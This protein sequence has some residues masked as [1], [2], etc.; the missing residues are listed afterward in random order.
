MAVVQHPDALLGLDIGRIN[1]RVN[2]FGISD[3]KF[4]LLGSRSLATSLGQGFHI[5]T[6]VGQAM[7]SLQQDTGHIFLDDSGGLLK[8][9]DRIGRG[10]DHVALVTSAGQRITAALLGLT[11]Q[12]SLLAGTALVDSLPLNQIET[13]GLVHLVDEINAIEMLVRSR[14]EIIIITGGEDGG[15]EVSIQSWIE[16]VRTSCRLMPPPVK[17]VVLYA[18]N[19]QLESIARRRLEPVARLQIAPNLQPGNG[20]IDL[21]PAQVLLE[22]EILTAWQRAL[23]GL[24]EI[25]GLSQDLSGLTVRS[26]DRMIRYLSRN[27]RHHPGSTSQAGVLAVDLGAAHTTVTAGLGGSCATVVQDKFFDLDHPARAEVCQAIKNWSCEPVSLEEADQFLCNHAIIPA[28]VPETRKELALAQAYAHYR[29]QD[30]LGRLAEN[31]PW[32]EFH[33]NSGLEGNYEPVIVSGGILTAA[34]NP[35]GVMLTLL[36]GLQ[37]RGITTIVLDR[38]HLLPLL[39]IIGQAEPVLPAHLLSSPAFENLGT[40][41][42]VVGDFPTGKAVLTVRVGTQSGTN[43]T[44]DIHAGTLT[45][46]E[47]PQG[48]V[49][50]LELVPHRQVDVGFGGRGEG[51]RLKVTGGMLGVVID[52]RGRPVRLPVED[53]ARSATLHQWL[54]TLGADRE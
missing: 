28:W 40:V 23:P 33:S 19:P 18:G 20:L 49:G 17:P 47:I 6:G 21:V 13:L 8:P 5:G 41:I 52:A 3:G 29:L 45:R 53:G 4:R 7:Q 1:T 26:M 54:E 36:N 39:G 46:L 43:Y 44:A 30:A 22:R 48:D 34:P 50:V 27:Q 14:P 51:G 42:S 11:S 2:L 25:F 9:V 35:E 31:T 37:P 10:V 38:H 12:G 24:G 32:F 15:A 16:I